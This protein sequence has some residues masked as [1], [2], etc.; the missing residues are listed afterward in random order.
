MAALRVVDAAVVVVDAS[1]G[2]KSEL[3]RLWLK[4][5]ELDLPCL[6]FVNGLDKE[7]TSFESTLETCSRHFFDVVPIPVTIP[8]H[9]GGRFVGVADVSSEN[10]YPLL[11]RTSP[12][13]EQHSLDVD[14]QELYKDARSRLVEAVAETDE[15]LLGAVHLSGAVDT[16]RTLGR[17][18]TRDSYKTTPSSLRRI[19]H[20]ECGSL[21][22]LEC[23]GDVVALAKRAWGG[24]S[25]V[26]DSP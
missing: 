7:G 16:G 15:S 6:L 3:D 10:N 23:H 9:Q 25:V 21:V 22:T 8:V 20:S 24:S 11:P 5:Q 13:C 18:A 1:S 14:Q 17:S 4:I 19:C 12:K 26:R 2:V